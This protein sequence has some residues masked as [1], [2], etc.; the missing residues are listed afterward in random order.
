MTELRELGDLCRELTKITGE[1]TMVQITDET[2]VIMNNKRLFI[3]DI[4]Q[5]DAFIGTRGM[6][7]ASGDMIIITYSLEK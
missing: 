3:E 5:L 2:I 1:G 4:K 6:I 7:E